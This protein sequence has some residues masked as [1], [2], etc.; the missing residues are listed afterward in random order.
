MTR[1]ADNS[2]ATVLIKIRFLQQARNTSPPPNPNPTGLPE[3]GATARHAHRHPGQRSVGPADLGH[4]R[5]QQGDHAVE[6]PQDQLRHQRS[7][8]PAAPGEGA[9]S[10]A[11][12]L[13]GP[14]PSP[15]AGDLQG[16]GGLR[17]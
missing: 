1:N 11:P 10:D 9:G 14:T 16:R 8:S 4:R 13:P 6:R 3:L 17:R 15:A 7:D 2:G 12:P 5:G